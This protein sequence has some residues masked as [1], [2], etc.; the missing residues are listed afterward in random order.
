MERAAKQL[1][2]AFQAKPPPSLVE[3]LD[4]ERRHAERQHENIVGTMGSTR[5]GTDADPSA[6]RLTQ[7][8]SQVPDMTRARG[9]PDHLEVPRLQL[10]H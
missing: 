8:P 9:P 6:L 5:F 2:A 10:I 4:D 3:A 7:P 1:G